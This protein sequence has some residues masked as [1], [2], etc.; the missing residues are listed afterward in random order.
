[1]E[2][3]NNNQEHQNNKQDKQ[4]PLFISFSSIMAETKQEAMKT[5]DDNDTISFTSLL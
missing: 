4:Q 3:I 5:I 2:S 1:M